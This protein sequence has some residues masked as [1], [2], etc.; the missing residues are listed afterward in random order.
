MIQAIESDNLIEAEN[1]INLLKAKLESQQHFCEDR[2]FF[3][4]EG[5]VMA[6]IS[7][8][9]KMFLFC[10]G[11]SEN[12]AMDPH[13]G[14]FYS[15]LANLTGE[16]V[17]GTPKS[18]PAKKE[19]V[20]EPMATPNSTATPAPTAQ[21]KTKKKGKEKFALPVASHQDQDWGQNS[22]QFIDASP[23]IH[24][25]KKNKNKNSN[26]YQSRNQTVSESKSIE[27]S[28]VMPASAPAVVVRKKMNSTA[29]EASSGI[30]YDAECCICF[31]NYGSV[32]D[33]KLIEKQILSCNHDLCKNCYW[34]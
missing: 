20:K 32:V 9:I 25:K 30:D 8:L 6:D 28:S 21:Q 33:E 19:E 5:T 13:G 18:V 3:D 14:N 11:I 22:D 12:P 10:E 7:F 23:Y 4:S 31:E 15:A 26:S 29:T 1:V 17:P 34:V 24:K 2:S 27:S 16:N